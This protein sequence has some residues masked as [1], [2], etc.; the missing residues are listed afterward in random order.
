MKRI[1]FLTAGFLT[2]AVL[3]IG[4]TAKTAPPTLSTADRV[5]ISSLEK[6]KQD[7]A[8]TW[9]DAQQQELAIEREWVT[10]H[11]GWTIDP[12]TFAVVAEP[13]PAEAP[14]KK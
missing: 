12:Q 4:Q 7:A 14:A 6:T 11:P 13:K 2:L 3:L 1:A 8:K 10:A 9:Q 5:A